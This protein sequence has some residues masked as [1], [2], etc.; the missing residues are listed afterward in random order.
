MREA[1]IQLSRVGL[2]FKL[3][4]GFLEVAIAD[5]VFIVHEDWGD[6][7]GEE[8]EDGGIR[9]EMNP[10]ELRK[11]RQAAGER[12]GIELPFCT[13]KCDTISQRI[14]LS[15][16][17]FHVLNGKADEAVS[18]CALLPVHGEKAHAFAPVAGEG[19]DCAVI[20][21]VDNEVGRGGVGRRCES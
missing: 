3:D 7:I 6:T 19:K 21:T 20:C 13:R 12:V 9:W 15:A 17:G 1:D 2:G 16:P 18:R 4:A 5:D 8:A 11:W 10:A 14:K